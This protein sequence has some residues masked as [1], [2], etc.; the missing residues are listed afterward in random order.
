MLPLID[1]ITRAE[2]VVRRRL[3]SQLIEHHAEQ[4]S[5]QPGADP[6]HVRLRP[7]GHAMALMEPVCLLH[8]SD[9]AREIVCARTGR[10]DTWRKHARQQTKQVQSFR[11]MPMEPPSRERGA[12][13]VLGEV[14]MALKS[15]DPWYAA[16]LMSRL[17]RSE[18]D[19]SIGHAICAGL[20]CQRFQLAA[21]ELPT[22]V[23]E[24]GDTHSLR[25]VW[26]A[27]HSTR[28]EASRVGNRLC[29]AR[30]GAGVEVLIVKIPCHE[31]LL[32]AELVGGEF[33]VMLS[34]HL[35]CVEASDL[36]IS[37]VYQHTRDQDLAVQTAHPIREDL[38]LLKNSRSTRYW[39]PRDTDP[40]RSPPGELVF[41]LSTAVRG[42]VVVG[43]D[44]DDHTL[45]V[46]PGS[47]VSLTDRPAEAMAR[48]PDG[49]LLLW[50]PDDEDDSRGDL[51]WAR[52]SELRPLGRLE[53]RAPEFMVVEAQ[54]RTLVVRHRQHL[55]LAK[56]TS[57]GTLSP[58]RQTVRLPTH[59]IVETDPEGHRVIARRRNHV[60][61]PTRQGG[62]A[63]TSF[64]SLPPF[65]HRSVLILSGDPATDL[66]DVGAYSRAVPILEAEIATADRSV[67]LPRILQLAAAH[68]MCARYERALA[69]LSYEEVDWRQGE[70]ATL[71]HQRAWVRALAAAD[72]SPERAWLDA[73]RRAWEAK[74]D[75]DPL[76]VITVLDELA[77]A[78]ELDGSMLALRAHA[79]LQIQPTTPTDRLRHRVAIAAAEN[80]DRAPRVTDPKVR[81]TYEFIRQVAR[82]SAQALRAD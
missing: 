32:T 52:A 40:R 51:A 18:R 26:S 68:T 58:F 39:A 67:L 27:D 29:L 7:E 66:L 78:H 62:P 63:T 14:A 6:V 71:A 8:L 24:Q 33:R 36:Q 74:Q 9:N 50:F 30:V 16:V 77:E 3:L 69:T 23:T 19:P 72:T 61:Q 48:H 11:P 41:P 37:G 82:R 80:A 45:L 15:G 70:R 43:T 13:Q 38:W 31:T 64:A 56:L 12:Q 73:S 35:V 60:W 44:A 10:N 2:G 54:T 59:T 47:T 76:R 28:F 25:V 81:I 22:L 49:G 5:I 4:L 55:T 57:E 65:R 20:S 53:G 79:W 34:R 46:A 75:G 42:P 17:A 1:A 21:G